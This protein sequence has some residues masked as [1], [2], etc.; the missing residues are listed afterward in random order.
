MQFGYLRFLKLP[1]VSKNLALMTGGD[2]L[3]NAHFPLII[4]S[5][6]LSIF[7]GLHR[8]L[9]YEHLSGHSSQ[10]HS[11]I[12][13]NLGALLLILFFSADPSIVRHHQRKCGPLKINRNI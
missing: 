13:K 8:F 5:S 6:S 9:N 1:V 12:I 4:G 2:N 3:F 11:I 7:L 10:S